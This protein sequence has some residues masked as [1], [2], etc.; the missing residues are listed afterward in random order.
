MRFYE[1]WDANNYMNECPQMY[2]DTWMQIELKMY[3]V[4]CRTNIQYRVIWM[5]RMC[6]ACLWWLNRMPRYWYST[7]NIDEPVVYTRRNNSHF[8]F[9]SKQPIV[10]AKLWRNSITSNSERKMCITFEVKTEEFYA[11]QNANSHPPWHPGGHSEYAAHDD[12]KWKIIFG[13]I[14]DELHWFLL[15]SLCGVA[16]GLAGN[17]FRNGRT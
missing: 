16:I 11:E 13:N 6:N 3:F 15:C 14:T 8:I 17:G 9:C 7:D 2:C 1:K 10:T 12:G 5:L 4:Y